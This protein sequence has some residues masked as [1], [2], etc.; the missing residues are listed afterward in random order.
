MSTPST[1][2]QV[3][4][5]SAADGARALAGVV[6]P[7]L[8][9][10]AIARRPRAVLGA[11]AA[12]LDA[13]AVRTMRHLRER[14][15][16]GPVQ[17]RIPRRRF[18]FLLEPD[19]VHRV[20]NASP[21]P[22]AAATREKRG[23][24]GHFQPEGVLVSS[25]EERAVRKPFNDDVLEA[26]SPV[27]QHGQKM[28][29]AVQEEMDALL[30]HVEFTGTLV[31]DDFVRAWMRMVRRIVLG[32]SARDDEAVT[33]D[34]VR[35]RKDANWSFVKPTR[36]GHRDRLLRRL[37]D[38]VDRAEPGSLA[39]MVASV[40]APPGTEPHQQIPQ[41][42]FAFDA[43]TWATVRA[44][45][46]VAAHPGAAQRARDE[47][48]Q[49]PDLPFLRATVLESLRLWPTTP[50]ILRDTTEETAWAGGSLPA[51]A[52][53]MIFAPF[54]HRDDTRVP[55]AHRFAPELWMRERTD[56][57]W[58]FVPFSGGPAMCS[59]RNV[60]LLAASTALGRLLERHD[61]TLE[62]PPLSADRPL[63][64]TLSPFHL[65]FTPHPLQ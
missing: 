32:D 40:P 60:V 48:P 27:H 14:Y 38:Y 8:A 23:A 65:R 58:P 6:L 45:A 49:S 46:L 1:E 21:E 53:V 35:L 57:D 44:L 37:A 61:F 39:Q 11:Q 7:V 43:G 20:L 5:T 41:W 2:G 31:W 64:G 52:S 28:A 54:F 29:D 24:L 15:G 51:G 3:P 42:L 47:L 30:G 13:R 16:P 34:L 55:E 62:D 59:G 12:E 19:Q 4:T 56:A 33:D 18:T 26:G 9:R 36:R 25:P 63:P 10:G 50:A 22:F 17:V